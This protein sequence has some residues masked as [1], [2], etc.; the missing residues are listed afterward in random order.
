MEFKPLNNLRQL[1][2]HPNDPVRKDKVVG[3][4]YKISCEECKATYV[5]GN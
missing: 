3:P 4:V 2:V 5:E 1:L